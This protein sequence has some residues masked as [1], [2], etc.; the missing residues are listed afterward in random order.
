MEPL[1]QGPILFDDERPSAIGASNEPPA[2]PPPQQPAAAPQPQQPMVT[3]MDP[4]PMAQAIVM[5]QQEQARRA[6]EA[7]Q[8]DQRQKQMAAI[9][10]PPTVPQ[11]EAAEALILEAPALAG[12]FEKFGAWAANAMRAQAEML[13]QATQQQIAA[14]QTKVYELTRKDAMREAADALAGAGMN[15]ADELI[16]EL[17]MR[18]R[19]NPQTYWDLVTNPTALIRG[20]KLVADERGVP[21]AFGPASLPFSPNAQPGG[22]TYES[23]S[24][25]L[26]LAERLLRRKI[27]PEYRE[28]LFN[29]PAWNQR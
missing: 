7:Q 25:E 15:G 21:N 12:Q 26:A 28:Q 29:N 5:A 9:Y 6:W 22:E 18:L 19:S 14:S 16:S 20:A 4:A 10:E 1:Q 3:T 11:G 8:W 2:S 27:R 23:N 24:P 17:E 13:W